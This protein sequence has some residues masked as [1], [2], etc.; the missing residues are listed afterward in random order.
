MKNTIIAG[1]PHNIFGLGDIQNSGGLSEKDGSVQL[2]D[3]ND[4][5]SERALGASLDLDEHSIELPGDSFL[6]A[7]GDVAEVK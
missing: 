5:Y 2:D 1:V 6:F 7:R 3:Q 4:E